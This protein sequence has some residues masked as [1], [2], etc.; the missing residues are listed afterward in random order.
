MA[1]VFP[2]GYCVGRTILP[3]DRVLFGAPDMIATECPN[4]GG[5]ISA[6]ARACIH[7]SAGNKARPVAIAAAATLSILV[8][9]CG[10]ATIALLR[11]QWLPV[12]ARQQPA[13]A[14]APAAGGEFG[15]LSAAMMDCDAEAAKETSTL[16]FLVVPLKSAPSGAEQW[17]KKSLN[18]IGNAILL[19]ADDMLD[20]LKS[21]ALS[22]SAAPYL[23]SIRDETTGVVFKWSP[24]VGVKKFLNADADSIAQFKVQFQ[25][26]DNT[27]DA[28]WGA[29]FIRRK[30]NCYWVNAILDN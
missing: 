28:N 26:G 3:N 14:T 22:L 18:D 16:E 19:P 6:F 13:T 21:G 24:S 2:R 11:A 25:R 23:F 5:R 7:C 29:A 17:R 9:A 20:G 4:C 27:S 8:V 15:W 10:I 1:G 12:G 30:G